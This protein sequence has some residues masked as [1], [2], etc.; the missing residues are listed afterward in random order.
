MVDEIVE[1]T[2]DAT[3]E[4]TITPEPEA[5]PITPP[6]AEGDPLLAEEAKQTRFQRRIDQLTR[7]NADLQR[8][9]D[10]RSR[11]TEPA[12]PV[13]PDHE[14]QETDFTDY[15]QYLKALTKYEIRQGQAESARE[16]AT[17]H[18]QEQFNELSRNFE[19]QLQ[20][21]RVK[22]EDFDEVVAQPIYSS[23]TQ[24]ILLQSPQGA[25][26]AYFLGTNPHEALKLNQL[27]PVAI[28][29]EI[30]KMETRFS[31]QPKTVSAAPAPITPITGSTPVTKDPK[32][33]T[34]EE[35]MTWDKQQKIERLKVKPF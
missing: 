25:E 23:A 17:R 20:S 1:P 22:Y 21:A 34:T 15:G 35:W 4:P 27:S 12:V 3:P 2:P 24:E 29:R 13:T 8:E 32:N 9:L 18:H 14:P 16:T 11:P 19:P 6:V 31:M 10:V 33:M 7:K 26:I 5:A 28:A 30:V